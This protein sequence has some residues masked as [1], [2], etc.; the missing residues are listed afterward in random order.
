MER[1]ETLLSDL[2]QGI[3]HEPASTGVRFANYLID[4]IGFYVLMF[5]I[6]LVIGLM[7]LQNDGYYEDETMSGSKFGDFLIS[8]ALYMLYYTVFEGATK[9][10][11]LGKLI[12]GTT[13]IQEDG[14]PITWNKALMRSLSRLVPFEQLSA[15]WGTPWHDSWTQ[16]TV[17]KKNA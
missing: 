8:Y 11:S 7:Q 2:E 15:L 9:G 13:A 16:T 6:G 4:L 17:V 12:T 14:N 1:N 5:V 3:A 10:R